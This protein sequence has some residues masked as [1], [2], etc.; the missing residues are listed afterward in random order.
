MSRRPCRTRVHAAGG[1]RL[2]HA[3]FRRCGEVMAEQ[4]ITVAAQAQMRELL[5]A[6]LREETAE[7]AAVTSDA[8]DVDELADRGG[9]GCWQ[10]GSQMMARPI[11]VAVDPGGTSTGYV[12]R[13]LRVGDRV[14][15]Y[16]V[17]G[18]LPGQPLSDYADHVARTVDE[19]AQVA[20]C[21][22]CEASGDNEQVLDLVHVAAEG[23]SPP[24]PHLGLIA[25]RGLLETAVVL[26]A[27]I[28]RIP[29][30]VIVDPAEHGKGPRNAYPPSLWGRNESEKGTGRL[31]H[32]RSAWDI[33]GA[34]K[35]LIRIE[36]FAAAFDTI[37][38]A[39]PTTQA[40]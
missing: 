38:A 21:D 13:D 31:R 22:A 1:V 2:A 14:P 19:L 26:G 37:D 11:I 34:V 18:R 9:F 4:L 24:S 25:V 40:T 36:Q 33:A 5:L 35:T 29:D 8:E 10:P 30:V 12:T 17:I 32:C 7:L 23:I 28:G 3:R 15:S 27:V 20:A 6:K 39:R 16:G